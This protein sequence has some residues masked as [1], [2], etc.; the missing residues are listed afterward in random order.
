MNAWLKRACL[1]AA[2]AVAA[3]AF[4]GHAPDQTLPNV[5]YETGNLPA[6][7]LSG[8]ATCSAAV[9][10]FQVHAYNDNFYIL[11]ESGCVNAEKPFLYLLFGQERAILFDTGAGDDTDAATGRVPD[12]AGAVDKVIQQWLAKNNRRSLP[13]VV[14]HLHSHSDHTWGDAQFIKRADTTFV[15]PAD[16]GVLKSFFGIGQWPEQLGSFDLG[17][18]VL[19][20][21]PIP[22]HDATSIAVY[23]RQTAVLLTGDSVYPGRIYV[24]VPDPQVTQA[25]LQRLVDFTRTRLVAHV[26]GSH[27]EQRGPYAD[28]PKGQNYSPQEVGLALGRA[29]LHEMLEASKLRSGQGDQS[30]ITQKAYR[31]FTICGVY[32]ACA[33]VNVPTQETAKP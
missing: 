7:W 21:I 25:S 6:T 22:G 23:D 8:S 15:K 16:V 27:I 3:P 12:V 4:A 17:G 14:T 28:N 5:V 31:D 33:P 10:D 2:A 1:V 13:L 20:I 30:R 18:R 9:E 26:L 19:D 11:R 32:P 29:H 24:N